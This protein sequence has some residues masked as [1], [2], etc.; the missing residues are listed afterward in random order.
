MTT[1]TAPDET[2]RLDCLRELSRS[3]ALDGDMRT[4]VLAAVADDAYVLEQLLWQNGLDQAPDPA[5]QLGA[6]GEAVAAALEQRAGSVT[7]QLTA[8]ELME[9]AREALK[10]TFDASVHTLLDERFTSLDHLDG[11]RPDAP[12]ALSS[13]R[14]T[15][16]RSS[17]QL[18]SD[19]R[20][21]A[22]DCMAVARTMAESGEPGAAAHLAR[23]ADL[24]SF[25]AFL[26]ETA[27][28]A[29]DLDGASVDLRWQLARV[30]EGRAESS[31]QRATSR[32][33]R[34]VALIGSAEQDRLR[35]A[36]EPL[37]EQWQG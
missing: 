15:D 8:R 26:L 13:G 20:V 11:L 31:E 34:L 5:A 36:F 23:Q 28:V 37:P 10:S 35:C 16:G 22:A 6:V 29:G 4:A 18:E 30:G 27:A 33:A 17:A 32:R 24:A 9:A 14:R 21:A 1:M 25:E 19:L 12:D 2:F 3:S 7:G